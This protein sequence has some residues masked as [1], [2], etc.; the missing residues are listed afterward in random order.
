MPRTRSRAIIPLAGVRNP[1]DHLG[2]IANDFGVFP[3][4]LDATLLDDNFDIYFN[5]L[6]TSAFDETYV[7]SLV[8]AN[9]DMK[10]RIGGPRSRA[11][12]ADAARGSRPS[13]KTP[14]SCCSRISS[15][16]PRPMRG[17]RPLPDR[18]A[19]AA[20]RC[21]EG[22]I[23]GVAAKRALDEASS[24]E[25]LEAAGIAFPPQRLVRPQVRRPLPRATSTRRL[26]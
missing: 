1:I 3:K 5:Y 13:W 21:A 19:A 23:T 20:S 12:D 26:R 16:R 10:R 8:S 25:L 14:A 7:D 18:L 17:S 9:I 2:F 15:V 4:L 11:G 22:C 6:S 24:R